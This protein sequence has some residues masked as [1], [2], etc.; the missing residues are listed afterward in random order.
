M[1]RGGRSGKG[2]FQPMDDGGNLGQLSE[3]QRWRFVFL[4]LDEL[5]TGLAVMMELVLQQAFGQPPQTAADNAPPPPPTPPAPHAQQRPPETTQV[6]DTQ[7]QQ[8][9]LLLQQQ[10][11]HA[12]QAQQAFL[13]QATACSGDG[14]AGGTAT[15]CSGATSQAG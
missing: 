8:H 5:A 1:G 2:W 10:H 12:Q 6:Q 7:L 14:H 15:A 3:E 9:A 4:R 13:L 11:Q